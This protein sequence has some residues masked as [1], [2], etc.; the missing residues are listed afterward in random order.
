MNSKSKI[1][2]SILVA[3]LILAIIGLTVGLVI[4]ASQVNVNN[5]MKV[6]YKATNV[7]CSIDASGL[8][9]NKSYGETE[10]GSIIK[11]KDSESNYTLDNKTLTISATSNSSTIGSVEFNE[12]E[13]TAAGRAVYKFTVKNTATYDAGTTN[14][15]K[16]DVT[17][18]NSDAEAIGTGNIKVS[19]AD[20]EANAVTAINGGTNSST[21]SVAS[22]PTVDTSAGA[23]NDGITFYVVLTV[24]NNSLPAELT[25]NLLINITRNETA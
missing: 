12:V 20:T 23:S 15:F 6:T 9:Y 10:T 5:S 19:V 13:L 24:D 25:A 8:S 16:V 4:V 7:Q 21:Y 17:V 18:S 22:V 11:I 1:A 2:M 3:V 14:T